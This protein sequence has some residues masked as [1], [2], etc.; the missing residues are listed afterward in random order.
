[1]SYPYLSD[2]LN[3]VLGTQWY[4]PIAM[5]G[6]FVAIALIVGTYLTT[7]E[8]LRYEQLEILPGKTGNTASCAPAHQLVPDLVLVCAFFGIVGARVFHIL[9]YPVEFL[10]DP[11]SMIFTRSGFSIYG[12][13]IFGM[14]A[15]ICYLKKYSIPITPALDAAAPSMI[16]GYGI[17]R[18]GC[19][20]SGDGDWGILSN[21]ALKPSWLPD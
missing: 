20:V 11:A 19:Q 12:G 15:G 10:K 16:L 14:I 17:G 5:F 18:I 4:I 3:A 9:D 1:M 2:V 21:L 13:L 6:T 7:K 8:F